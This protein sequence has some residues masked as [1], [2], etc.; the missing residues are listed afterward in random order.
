MNTPKIAALILGVGVASAGVTFY[1]SSKDEPA[2][3]P[4]PAAVTETK[5]TPSTESVSARPPRQNEGRPERGGFGPGRG[6]GEDVEETPAPAGIDQD[7]WNDAQRRMRFVYGMAQSLKDPDGRWQERM[8]GRV[9]RDSTAITNSLGLQGEAAG[10]MQ[11][12]LEG[13]MDSSLENS[14]KILDS[15]ISNE[16][17]FVEYSALSEMAQNGKELTAEQKSRMDQLKQDIFGEFYTDGQTASDDPIRDLVWR[18][19]S[20][21]DWYKDDAFLVKAAAEMPE[22]EG[23]ALLEYAGKLDYLDRKEYASERVINIQRSVNISTEQAQALN[24]LYLENRNPTDEQI[25]QIVPANQVEAVKKA[26]TSD[27]N[28]WGGGRRGRR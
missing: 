4:A 24:N 12:L 15:M 22:T 21:G 1:L 14:S 6:P 19:P 7:A 17:G 23:A 26:T 3:A 8:K 25:S 16:Q 9:E 18:N 20:S 5:S 28:R 13:R 10:Q 27:R 11:K 2:P